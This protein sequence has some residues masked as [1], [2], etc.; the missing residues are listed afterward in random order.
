M[1]LLRMENDKFSEINIAL[2]IFVS[3]YRENIKADCR[4]RKGDRLC[5]GW[6]QLTGQSKPIIHSK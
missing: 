6:D 5:E 2:G 3:L 4:I 1:N